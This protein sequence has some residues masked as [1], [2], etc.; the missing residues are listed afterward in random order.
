[1][2]WDLIKVGAKKY[3]LTPLFSA[4]ESLNKANEPNWGGL[5]ILKLKFQ[6]DDCEIHIG[7]LKKNFSLVIS[8]VF[9]EVAKKKPRFE[10][11]I[12]N[13]VIKIE[14]PIICEEQSELT[15][16]E[17]YKID[18]YNDD[19]SID[20]FMKLWKITFLTNYPVMIYNF[21]KDELR[22]L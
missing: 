10:N 3:L 20:T 13:E 7:G 2:T 6:F 1:L 17:K 15:Q 4:L 11:E 19:Y 5:K 12:G 14:L 9:N 22:V 16:K 21:N 8:T 18:V